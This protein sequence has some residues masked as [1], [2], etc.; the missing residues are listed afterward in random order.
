MTQT[1]APPSNLRL[2][3]DAVPGPRGAPVLG[4]V[5]PFLRDPTSFMLQAVQR[6]GDLV[7]LKLGPRDL[8]L[9]AHPDMVRRVV[10]E[11]VRNYEKRYGQIGDLL[12]AGLVTS[13]GGQWLQQRRLMQPAFHHQKIAG[14][15]EAIVAET[16]RFLE[17]WQQ[18]ARAGRP[19]DAAA[20]MMHLTQ[21]IIVRTMFS[22]DVGAD[23]ERVGDAFT[24]A[25]AYVVD[26]SFQVIKPPPDWPT[27]ANKR[28]RAALAFLESKVYGMIEARRRSGERPNDL[29]SMLLDAQDAD[30]GVTMDDRQIRDEVMT[31][32]F[33]GHETTAS[34]LAWTLSLLAT[35]P[36]IERRLREEYATVLGG[37]TPTMADL[38]HLPYGRMVI[39]EV[40]RLYPPGWLF[41]RYAVADDQL[42]EYHIPAGSIL[43]IS[44]FVL[45]HLPAFWDHPEGF[46]PERFTPER[47]AGRHKFAYMPFLTGPRK[48]IGD[49]FALVEMQ[50]VLPLIMQR[51][52][53]MALPGRPVH[54]AVRGTL[55]P[56]PVWL[57]VTEA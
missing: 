20:E 5:G 38:P 25:L 12:G 8:L 27:P 47:S 34:T 46:D 41:S 17:R 30:T 35:H 42:G 7:R 31:I 33:A 45:H 32:F 54:P 14:F 16:E 23:A 37:R 18:A 36:P 24:Y 49:G 22:G 1:S 19:I 51:F 44:P 40:L 3:P 48:C 50:L 4:V 56:S 55:R 26:R 6:Y 28:Y 39:D 53:F 15:A 57:Q 2:A 11:N 52:Q 29:L 13:N 10:L 21:A 9:V 43:S